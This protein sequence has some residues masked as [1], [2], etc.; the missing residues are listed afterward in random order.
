MGTIASVKSCLIFRILKPS[1]LKRWP[2]QSTTPVTVLLA[3]RSTTYLFTWP[4][5]YRSVAYNLHGFGLKQ[6]RRG[7]KVN[8][9]LDR[10][11]F[12]CSATVFQ[13]DYGNARFKVNMYGVCYRFKLNLYKSYQNWQAYSCYIFVFL[14]CVISKY[15]VNAS[16]H[17]QNCPYP[18]PC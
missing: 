17:F 15:I 1:E 13:R 8:L 16:F 18:Q 7:N 5:S 11:L 9:T 12:N 2:K 6:W 4:G 10:Y 3:R 14:S